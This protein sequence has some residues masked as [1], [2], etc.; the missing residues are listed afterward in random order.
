VDFLALDAV[1]VAEEVFIVED[2][3]HLPLPN[4]EDFEQ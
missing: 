1:V 2:P 4:E 3:G